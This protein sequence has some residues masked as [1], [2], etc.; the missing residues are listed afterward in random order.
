MLRLVG[1]VVL[2]LAVGLNTADVATQQTQAAPAVQS[3]PHAL[4]VTSYTLP[5]DKLVKAK[6][7][8]LLRGRLRIIDTALS[9]LIL[10]GILHFGVAA[11][12]RD[13]AEH[14]S[15][16]RFVQALIFIPLLL[17][18]IDLLGLPLEIYQHHISLQYGLSI[19]RWGS[20]FADVLKGEAI[21]L[22]LST[23]LLGILFWIIVRSPR[24]WWFYFWLIAVPILFFVVFIAPYVIDPLFN[25]FEPLEK[26]H[27]DLVTAIE[28][29]V[30]RAGMYIPP[31]RMFEMKASEKVTTLNAYVTGFGA[32]KRVVVYDTTIQKLTVPEILF[33]FGHE[34]G[35]YVLKHVFRGLVIGAIALLLAFYLI[36]RTCGWV[37]AR[38]KERWH[39]R[40]LGDWAALPMLF[41]LLGVFGF[42]AEP[43]TNTYSRH[44]EHQ[45]DIYGLEVT[46][47]INPD[48]KQAAAHSFQVLG[49]LSLDYPYPSKFTVLW[50]Y[51]HPPTADRVR[52]SIDYDPWAN[53][54]SPKY[55]K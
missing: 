3:A 8:Y 49:E 51:N 46:H 34:M 5:P 43:I 22:I 33:V 54:L 20:W 38:F 31:E 48:S 7:L 24:R 12:Y 1:A 37:L 28:R 27:A 35:H 26:T 25:K 13:W 10:L 40:E 42:I 55:L 23:L 14:A 18:S 39:I 36:Y 47:S 52:F 21:G 16:W 45:A 30:E 50:F 44:V 11:R 32:S 2:S 19:Q 29:V 6:A 15:N 4:P 9:F 17:L 53:G 41:L